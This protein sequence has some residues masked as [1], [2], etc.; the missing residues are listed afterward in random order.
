VQPPEPLEL[1]ESDPFVATVRDGWL[2][3][4]GATDDKGQFFMLLRAVAELAAEQSLPVNVLVLGDGEEEV[5]GTTAWTWLRD[6]ARRVDT[7]LVFDGP[8]DSGEPELVLATRGLVSVEVAVTTGE[9]DLHSGHYGGVALNAVNALV[10]AL[11]E[12]LPREGVLPRELHAGVVQPSDDERARWSTAGDPAAELER[13]GARPLP[14][15]LGA[16]EDRRWAQP[17][18]DLH[19]ILGGKPGRRNTS[20]PVRAS[21]E[22]SVRLVPDQEVDEIGSAVERLLRRAAPPGATLEVAWDGVPPARIDPGAEV[23]RVAADALERGFGE[24]PRLVRAGGTLP[25]FS[26]LAELGIPPVLLG[27]GVPEGNQHAPNERLPLAALPRG[28]RA[29]RAILIAL[30]GLRPRAG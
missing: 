16:Y 18:L 27:F 25:V 26:A 24:R 4:R 6:A 21:A 30:G 17:S 12:V 22:L 19:G 5:G 10:E 9:V 8:S 14:G 7:A 3:G 20:I 29:A 1:W 2:Y 13:R 11:A 15:A 23:V 28:I